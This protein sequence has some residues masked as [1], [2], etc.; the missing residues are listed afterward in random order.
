L[1]AHW[2]GTN[3]ARVP[4]PDD[5]A[6]VHGGG[7]FLNAVSARSATDAW[8]AGYYITSGGTSLT[9]ILRWNG[10]AWVRA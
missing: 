9:L 1:L 8:A 7:N 5:P 2:N 10:S 6:G 4:S 3:W